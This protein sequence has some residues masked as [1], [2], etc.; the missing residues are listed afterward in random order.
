MVVPQ[1]RWSIM[2]NPNLKWMIWGYPYELETTI[3]T[4]M[5]RMLFH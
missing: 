1:N 5:V 2:E 4:H 3:Y